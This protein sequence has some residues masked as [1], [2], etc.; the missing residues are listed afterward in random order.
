M[1]EKDKKRCGLCSKPISSGVYCAG[2]TKR[3]EKGESAGAIMSKAKDE[4]LS[5]MRVGGKENAGGKTFSLPQSPKYNAEAVQKAINR[6]PKIK[7][8]EARAIHSLLKGRTGD[9]ATSLAE[10]GR[11]LESAFEKKDNNAVEALVKAMQKDDHQPGT[12]RS[13]VVKAR[14]YVARGEQVVNVKELLGKDVQPVGDE[15]LSRVPDPVALAKRMIANLE[16]QYWRAEKK[17]DH[18]TSSAIEGRLQKLRKVVTPVSATDLKPIPITKGVKVS[19]IVATIPRSKRPG[20]DAKPFTQNPALTNLAEKVG[21]MWRSAPNTYEGLDK[22]KVE[23]A[24]TIKAAGTSPKALADYIKKMSTASG[25]RVNVSWLERM[26]D[27]S[28]FDRDSDVGSALQ[29]LAEMNKGLKAKEI[30]TKYGYSIQFVLD[31]GNGKFGKTAAAIKKAFAADVQPVGDAEPKNRHGET[32]AEVQKQLNELK[33]GGGYLTKEQQKKRDYLERMLTSEYGSD[34]APET[35]GGF[36]K[37]DEVIYHHGGMKIPTVIKALRRD[38]N[39]HIA[40]GYGGANVYC[41]PEALTKATDVAPVGDRDED[42]MNV[43]DYKGYTITAQNYQGRF[44]FVIRK[45]KTI[46][47]WG[48]TEE[49]AKRYIDTKQ[50]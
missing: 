33:S 32:K 28:P 40:R 19:P 30:A 3:L 50:V 44:C 2:C 6:D 35:H 9:K 22:V 41:S 27:A 29:I 5:A 21:T 37:G 23:I 7:G 14:N 31:V 11:Q 13:V 36:K 26:T 43:T 18:A 49:Y 1:R 10:Y 34:A 46:K 25:R 39:I 48:H 15:D 47:G 38:G 16:D 17:G 24:A 20:R 4:E 45:G 12:I 42:K 8:K